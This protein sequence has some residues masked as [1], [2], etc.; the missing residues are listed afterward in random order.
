MVDCLIIGAGVIGLSLAYELARTG[1]KVRVVDRG[2]PGREASWAGAG[3]LPP[4]NLDTAHDA[5]TRL[6][7]LSDQLHPEWHAALKEETGIDNGYRRCGGI[8]LA[9]TKADRVALA[10]K[11]EYLQQR[12]ITAHRLDETE[13]YQL[14][15]TLNGLTESEK[16]RTACFL[17]GEAQLRNPRHLKALVAACLQRDVEISSGVS[18]NGFDLSKNRIAAVKT[19]NGTIPADQFCVAG[20]AWT[21]LILESL[22]R[23]LALKPIRGQMVLFA[24]R[25]PLFGRVI[26]EG[27]RYLV[28]RD[29]GRVLA[30]STEEDVGFENQNTSL[31]IAELIQFAV[32]LVEPLSQLPVERTWAGLRPATFDGLP[33]LGRMPDT[34]N[35]YLA[36]GH[37]RNGIFLSPA[38][39]VVLS[40]L[41]CK[42]SPQ[43]DLAPFRVDRD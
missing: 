15:P 18:V 41:I 38:T 43:I 24:A 31:A 30:G 3:I 13:L 39:A 20:G 12:S 14:E 9:H 33:Y 28:P 26:N 23:R 36:A 19:S 40:Q 8:Y 7:G 1:M 22:Q 27:L 21:P 42:A 16:I 37:F 2:E 11:I 6:G 17:P 29:D 34:E 35:L 5:F 32:R 25:Q 4:H 10:E